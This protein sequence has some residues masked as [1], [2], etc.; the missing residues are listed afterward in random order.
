M[1]VSVLLLPFVVL[2][3]F[4]A[5]VTLEQLRS[6][7]VSVCIRLYVIV[8]FSQHMWSYTYVPMVVLPCIQLAT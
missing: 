7:H 2:H 4:D 8:F 1:S 6:F 5:G 3:L